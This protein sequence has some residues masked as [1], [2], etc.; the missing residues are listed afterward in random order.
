M[1][2][3]VLR[4]EL[5]LFDLDETLLPTA[6]L[7]EARHS[8]VS[9]SLGAVPAY[10]TIDLHVGID[11]VVRDL[12]TIAR[13]GV[14]SSSPRW[15]V[16]QVLADH[17]NG[18]DFSVVVTYDDVTHI[19]PHPEPLLTALTLARVDIEAAV[20]VGDALVDWEACAAIGMTF[21]AAGWANGAA[22]PEEVRVLEDPDELLRML[23]AAGG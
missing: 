4:P 7:V 22:F 20:Y 2:T 6:A 21:F 13:V 3:P 5:I 11:T 17:L 19:K 15:Y 23:G 12:I 14:V 10:S 1:G 8:G 16:D 18:I 9:Q